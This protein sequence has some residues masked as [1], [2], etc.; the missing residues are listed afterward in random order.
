MDSTINLALAF[1]SKHGCVRKHGQYREAGTSSCPADRNQETNNDEGREN[2]AK[3]E[4]TKQRKRE[5]SKER[6][7]ET[8]WELRQQLQ[9][10]LKQRLDSNTH[11]HTHTRTH[12][13]THTHTQQRETETETEMQ[14]QADI[15]KLRLSPKSTQRTVSLSVRLP[16]CLSA[17]LSVYLSVSLSVC[18]F[19]CLSLCGR[20]RETEMDGRDRDEETGCFSELW[21]ADCLYHTRRWTDET[22][23][24]K[25]AASVSFG[26]Q[27][28]YIIQGD[29][30]TRQRRGNRLLQWALDSRLSISYKETDGRD[31]YEE[32]G[33]FSELWTADCLYQTRRWTDE[34]ET[35]KQAA[36]VSFGQQIVYIIQLPH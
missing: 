6:E 2:E 12:A 31:R 29:G 9:W 13:R 10:R 24:R 16:V 34:T 35:R 30:R 22:E 19:G 11:T 36:S 32:T 5:R 21:T 8:Q 26:Q 14:T 4:R 33:C 23:T 1:R 15:H 20:G 28:V 3:K 27:I 18:S 17:C 7:K 25:Q